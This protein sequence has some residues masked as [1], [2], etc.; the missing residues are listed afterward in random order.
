MA[1]LDSTLNVSLQDDTTGTRAEVTANNALL[2]EQAPGTSS[3]IKIEGDST[4]NIAEVDDNNRL[5]VSTLPVPP[6]GATPVTQQVGGN[7]RGTQD[8]NY[9]IPSG[10]T[11][12]ITFFEGTGQSDSDG[13]A[14][15]LFYDP[16][17]N[18]AGMTRLATGI[19]SGSTFQFQRDDS[20]VGDGT[21]RIKLRRRRLT[22]GAVETYAGWQGFLTL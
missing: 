18:G 3:I 9:T 12:T 11:L 7:D 2:V 15:E 20:Y 5:L 1:D 19:V 22:G 4:G 16:N 17:G 14:I 6:T 13:T 8:L 10:Q 21:R